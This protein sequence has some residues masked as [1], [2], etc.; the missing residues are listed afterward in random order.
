MPGTTDPITAANTF[1][2][3]LDPQIKS[4]VAINGTLGDFISHTI[5]AVILV[6]ALATFMYLLYGGVE[7]ILSGG[8]KG[9]I[10]GAKQKITQA[11]IGLAIVASAWAIF[12]LIMYFFGIDIIGN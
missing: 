7:W 9:K 6:A 5:P 3:N 4:R 12:Q 11:L 8:E 2:I 1:E 10:E